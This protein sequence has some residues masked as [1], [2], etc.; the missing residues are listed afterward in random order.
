LAIWG[1]NI[2]DKGRYLIVNADDFGQS[3]GVNRGIID[4]HEHGIVTS[5][6]LMV[7]WPNASEAAA[8]A[9]EHTDLSL[10][11]HVDLGE[12]AFR[13]GEW[14]RLYEVVAPSDETAM[15]DEIAR[16]LDTFRNL[17]GKDPTHLDSHQHVHRNEPLRSIMIE[18]AGKLCV[19]LRDFSPAVTYCGNFYGQSADGFPYPDGISVEALMTILESLPSGVTELGCHPAE[20]NDLAGMYGAE[21]CQEL[22]VLC[23]PM[24]CSAAEE[25]G[26]ELM[27]FSNLSVATDDLR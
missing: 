19:P 5:A 15:T 22:K 23:D 24:I 3:L 7:R 12:W 10:G 2:L 26:I 11:L 20:R 14:A 13:D 17:A 1:S 9:R 18:M 16:Q 4:A 6:S 21:R 27:S 8:Y 25:L